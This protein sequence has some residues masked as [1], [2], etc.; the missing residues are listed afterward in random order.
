[1]IPTAVFIRTYLGISATFIYRQLKGVMPE[2]SPSILCQKT[3]NLTIFPHDPIHSIPDTTKYKDKPLEIIQAKIQRAIGGFH[4]L[5]GKNSFQF[6]ENKLQNENCRLIHAHFGP[7][8]IMIASL[9]E[10]LK[11]PL[12][13]TLHGYDMSRLLNRR[14]YK[15]KLSELF[16]KCALVICV[17]E[18]FRKDAISLGC[19]PEKA[20]RHY[21]G[22]P[23]EEFTC[24]IPGVAAAIASGTAHIPVGRSLVCSSPEGN[25]VSSTGILPVSP[26]KIDSPLTFL[27]VARFTGKKGHSY[28]LQAFKNVLDA[29]VNG[30]LILAGD[31][32]LLEECRTLAEK[33]HIK[34]KVDFRG[35]MPMNE[36]PRLLETADVFIQHSITPE[37]GDTEGIPIGLMEAMAVGLPV[38]S[39]EHSGIPELVTHGKSGFLA[40]ERDIE[41]FSRHWMEIAENFE[42]R[43]EMG[44]FNRAR[45]EK[46]FNMTK[47]NEVLKSLYRRA[48]EG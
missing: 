34:D 8:G 9:A 32:P 33:L 30:K 3:E 1:M 21:I 40:P 43:Q 16:K 17:S 13:V 39:T 29:G 10:K 36:I 31:G 5:P 27:Q 15:Q 45:I 14:G 6:W 28:T 42:M 48:I 23:V 18:K 44:V 41:A 19:N 24:K 2:F 37:D 47:Q 38:L 46:E 22:V 25:P 26:K 35:K 7:E 20:V 11:I 12:I 4:N